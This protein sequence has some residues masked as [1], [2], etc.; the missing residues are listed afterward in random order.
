MKTLSESLT[1]WL[2]GDALVISHLRGKNMDFLLYSPSLNG[3][4]HYFI[5]TWSN[6]NGNRV[7]DIFKYISWNENWR[8]AKQVQSYLYETIYNDL[9]HQRK[10][11]HQASMG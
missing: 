4:G 6:R 10:K 9:V 5:G 7:A 1:H 8:R 11:Q 2:W 3:N